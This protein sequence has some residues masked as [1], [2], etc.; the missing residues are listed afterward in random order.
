[1]TKRDINWQTFAYKYAGTEQNNFERLAYIV[2]CE[3]H[4]IKNG[5]HYIVCVH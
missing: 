5:V 3:L 4:D 1:M 2:F